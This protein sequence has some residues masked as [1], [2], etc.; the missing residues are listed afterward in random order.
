MSRAW[1]GP[2]DGIYW[3][4]LQTH[5]AAEV[6]FNRAM[7]F[8]TRCPQ[9]FAKKPNETTKTVQL[10]HGP[11]IHFL[12]GNNYEDLRIETLD[13]MVIDEY[14]QQAPGL[15]AVVRP[16]LAVKHAMDPRLGWADKLSTPNGYD[17]WHDDCEAVKAEIIEACARGETPESAYFEAPSTCAPWWTEQEIASAKRTMSADMFA[18]EILAEFRNLMI[19][20][21]FGCY[22]S[23]N[24]CM[25]TPLS[26]NRLAGGLLAPHFPIVV[27]PDFNVSP[28]A[29][30]LMQHSGGRYYCFDMVWLERTARG[31]MEGAEELVRKLRG[32][33]IK[34]ITV[35]G[36][37]AGKQNKSSAAGETDYTILTS[38]L[39]AADIKW[40]N[41][42]PE[43]NPFIR[44]RVNTTNSRLCS[45]D[46][47]R[48]FFLHPVNC[49]PLKQD[50]ER[51]TWADLTG[52]PKD[53]MRGHAVSGVGY[54]L[55][56]LDPL[57]VAS[58]DD[59]KL[60]VLNN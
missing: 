48:T 32:Y 12:S 16:M 1:K 37:A 38:A 44:D 25:E 21:A 6:A 7:K 15:W 18:Q 30:P 24:E 51:V 40:I 2:R 29:W 41:S 59:F 19:G 10:M 35:I 39:T 55:H 4:I 22:S 33:G 56:V 47:T 14:R 11:N 3:Y 49:K 50:F 60:Y 31:T 9:A 8:F 53:P 17:H 46:G 20:Q 36:D 34:Q 45:A 43:A 42:T 13:G 58:G 28:M 23:A 57:R 27:A 5:R 26:M 54:A 52:K